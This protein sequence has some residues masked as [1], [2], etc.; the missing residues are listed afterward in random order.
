MRQ[1]VVRPQAAL[2]FAEA[3]KWYRKH[4]SDAATG[5]FES[6][7]R[8]LNTIQRNPFQYQSIQ[9]RVRRAAVQGFRYVIVYIVTDSEV[10]V[11][12]CLHTSRDPSLLRDRL[13]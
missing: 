4:N 10:M 2:E 6:V 8:I 5:F 7:Q 1:L 9:G 3:V 11:V 12:A 13:K